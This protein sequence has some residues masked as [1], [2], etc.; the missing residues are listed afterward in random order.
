M[1]CTCLI[2]LI[3]AWQHVYTICITCISACDTVIVS[4][5]TIMVDMNKH[6]LNRIAFTDEQEGQSPLLVHSNPVKAILFMEM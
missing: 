4:L 6:G 2:D 3:A 1:L 5:S